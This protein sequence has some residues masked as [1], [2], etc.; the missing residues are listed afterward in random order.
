M[1]VKGQ[2]DRFTPD[3]TSVRIARRPTDNFNN[4]KKSS[5]GTSFKVS[6]VIRQTSKTIADSALV[7]LFF[8]VLFLIVRSW[9][10]KLLVTLRIGHFYSKCFTALWSPWFGLELQQCL[11]L[12]LLS[13]QSESD[14]TQFLLSCLYDCV[15]K[16]S[17]FGF[18]S[19]LDACWALVELIIGD[20]ALFPLLAH[21]FFTFGI[22]P[23]CNF[24][25][26]CNRLRMKLL[27]RFLE[28]KKC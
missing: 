2:L 7:H 19:F 20:H 6:F 11:S 25:L 12:I 8:Q 27:F 17:W 14:S 23:S 18:W 21:Y 3:Q 28:P 24:A 5:N 16:M 1:L 15:L 22:A 9:L 4:K 13:F 10:T 26:E